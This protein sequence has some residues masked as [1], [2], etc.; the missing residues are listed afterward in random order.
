MNQDDRRNGRANMSRDPGTHAARELNKLMARNQLDDSAALSS[1]LVVLVD[2]LGG[3]RDALELIAGIG[4]Q[5]N[6]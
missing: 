2:E 6:V 1:M 3:I 4:E 5:D